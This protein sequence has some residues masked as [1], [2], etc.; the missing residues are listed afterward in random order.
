MNEMPPEKPPEIRRRLKIDKEGKAHGENEVPGA[1]F[2]NFLQSIREAIRKAESTS[3]HESDFKRLK[4]I[5]KRCLELIRETE[6]FAK[7]TPTG[8]LVLTRDETRDAVYE[9]AELSKEV[10]AIVRRLY[11][12]R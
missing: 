3:H 9:A 2:H 5:E 6:K 1:M 11:T 7:D 4:E 12:G 8:K 10:S